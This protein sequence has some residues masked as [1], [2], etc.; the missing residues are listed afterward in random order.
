MRK[1]A[2]GS[3]ILLLFMVGWIPISSTNN[4]LDSGHLNI[5]EEQPQSGM[6]E[7]EVLE[8]IV[9][10]SDD[11]F[12]T[13]Y[14]I[15]NGTLSNPYVLANKTIEGERCI[16]IRDTSCYFR[17]ENCTLISTY[18][19]ISMDYVEK[20]IISDCSLVS[21]SFSIF[22]RNTVNVTIRRNS[23]CG[24][25]QILYSHLC[26]VMDNNIQASHQS[27]IVLRE[28]DQCVINNNTVFMNN[29]GT[30]VSLSISPNSTIVNNTLKG[31]N[32][33]VYSYL[34]HN[35]VFMNNTVASII[36][37]IVMDNSSNNTIIGNRFASTEKEVARDYGTS[38]LWDDGISIGNAW[39][40]YQGTGVYNIPGN[41]GSTDHF[42][43]EFKPSF[44]IIFDFEGPHIIASVGTLNVDFVDDFPEFWSFVATVTDTTRVDTVIITVNEEP[45]LM[46]HQPTTENPDLYVYHHPNPR[47][48]R[49][50]YWANDSLGLSTETEQGWISCGVFRYTTY[51]QPTT[52]TTT[53]TT[54]NPILNLG[55][56]LI[57]G[58]VGLLLIFIVVVTIKKK[59]SSN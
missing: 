15:G 55:S 26:E 2:I 36:H 53:S 29:T 24:D 57:A 31:G 45:H 32:Y 4:Q 10:E 7:S 58:S 16:D 21:D 49:Y 37:A 19:G 11:D 38:N 12:E 47:F 28:C 8:P 34:S 48:M 40:D 22:L 20:G 3:L 50:S 33:G 23:I 1:P 25:I 13:T 35:S 18:S 27:A 30:I 56:T 52:T 46:I 6:I 17:I 59:Q 41:A 42:P 43:T 54:S 39:L 44:S 14:W 51:T 5:V 9:I